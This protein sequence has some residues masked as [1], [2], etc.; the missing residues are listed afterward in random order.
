MYKPLPDYLTVATSDIEG[1][2]LIAGRSI[3]ANTQLGMMHY[4]LDDNNVLRTPLGGFINHSETSNCYKVTK[5]KISYLITKRDIKVGE[6]LTLTY[7]LYKP[8]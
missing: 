4:Y 8:Q 2:G 3:K 7:S 1:L 6:E 5:G